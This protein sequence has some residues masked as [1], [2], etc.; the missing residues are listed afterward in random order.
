MPLDD[1]GFS[2]RFGWMNDRFGVSWQLNLAKSVPT[3][4]LSEI[5]LRPAQSVEFASLERMFF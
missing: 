2:Q 5:S 4:Y 1:Y 3:K